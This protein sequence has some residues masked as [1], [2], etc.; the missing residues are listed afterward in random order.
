MAG[1]LDAKLDHLY[2]L[3]PEQFVAARDALA[4]ELK[5]EGRDAVKAL[6]RPSV[7]AAL[8]NRLARE[9]PERV[10]ELLE[11]G[12]R[13][14]D[15][16]LGGSGD[17]REA[18]AAERAAVDVLV[19]AARGL[20]G[21]DPTVDRLRTLLR[22]TAG[23]DGLRA[24]LARGRLEREP[25]AGGA[26][27][28]VDLGDAAPAAPPKPATPPKP[29][30]PKTG[31]RRA[32]QG[33]RKREADATATQDARRRKEQEDRQAQE[34]KREQARLL[35]EARERRRERAAATT[36]AEKDAGRAQT[37]L[38]QAT[39]A[40]ARAREALEGAEDEEAQ[41]RDAAQRALR[42]LKTA[43][44]QLQEAEDDVRAIGGVSPA[45]S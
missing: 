35:R 24:A 15:A 23:D 2:H 40:T 5:G 29:A 7:V 37:R 27:P 34:A 19:K 22:G 43:Q 17:L 10:Q 20:G 14:R 41:A 11:A 33:A 16:Q 28:A 12:E 39:A 8:A 31:K 13:L 32:E 25:A 9:E 44:A 38:E 6:R 21:T 4:R 42:A 26:W 45:S 3:P 36:R 18:M 1:D 30:R